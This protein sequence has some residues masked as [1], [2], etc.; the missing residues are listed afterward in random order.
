MSNGM[1]VA[2]A[3][4]AALF[5]GFTLSQRALQAM[6]QRGPQP[7]ELGGGITGGFG[8]ISYK[9]KVWRIKFGGEEVALRTRDP[10]TGVETAQSYI[11]VVIIKST[12]HLTKTWYETQYVEGSNA[13]PDCASSDGVKPDLASPKRQ[14]DLC[15]TCKWNQYGSRVNANGTGRGKACQDTKRLAVVPYPDLENEGNGGPMLLRIPPASL[16][17]LAKFAGLMERNGYPFYGVSVYLY[18]EGDE[19]YPQI[20][21]KP[22]RPL[23]DA[24]F[25]VIE[26]Y[27]NDDRVAR[28]LNSADTTFEAPAAPPPVEPLFGAPPAA[29]QLPAPQAAPVAPQPAPQAVPPAPVPQAAPPAP[30]PQAPAPQAPVPPAPMQPLETQQFAQHPQQAAPQAHQPAPPPAA[31]PAP[32]PQPMAAQEAPGAAQAAPA[33]EQSI[34]DYLDALGGM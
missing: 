20:A 10:N 18:F 33:P 6:Q 12:T 8:V 25:A 13:A 32:A 4:P 27:R 23:S 21:F 26:A 2:G 11:E 28:V 15:A 34:D 14:N 31:A 7:S 24:E 1:V 17:N 29:A 5:P 9:G 30:V 19:A 16:A 22:A 3:N